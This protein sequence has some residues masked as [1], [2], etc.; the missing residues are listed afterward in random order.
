M[1]SVAKPYITEAEYLARERAAE[2]RSEYYRGEMFAMAGA[3]KEHEI[4]GLFYLAFR[5]RPCQFFG[6]NMRVKISPT[7]LYTYPDLSA[8]CGDP[9]FLDAEVDTLV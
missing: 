3:T 5:G 8:L 2:F 1:A 7:G 9:K 6:A 4:I